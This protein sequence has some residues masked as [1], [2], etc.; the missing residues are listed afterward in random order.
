MTLVSV[1]AVETASRRGLSMFQSARARSP[2]PNLNSVV[3]FDASGR[4]RRQ[5][6]KIVVKFDNIDVKTGFR[7]AVLT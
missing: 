1:A 3:K 4:R 6:D 5:I 7:S 2:R